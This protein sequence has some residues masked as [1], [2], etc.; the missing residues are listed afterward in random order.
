MPAYMPGKGIG[1]FF[2]AMRIDAFRPGEDFKKDMDQWIQ[3]F[4][5]AEPINDNKKVIIPGEP[6]TEIEIKRRKEG[7]PLVTDVVK[8]LKGL[9]EKYGVTL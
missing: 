1:H 6:E 7:I 3:A 2:G 4:K 8:D 5:N 9:A